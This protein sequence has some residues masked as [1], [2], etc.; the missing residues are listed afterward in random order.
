M[1]LL[2]NPTVKAYGA[3]TG[4]GGRRGLPGPLFLAFWRDGRGTLFHYPF[5]LKSKIDQVISCLDHPLLKESNGS[6]WASVALALS[7]VQAYSQR[8]YLCRFP[9][10]IHVLSVQC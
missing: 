5:K 10:H 9:S 7:S 4:S 2:I 8:L 1:F 3:L 6:L